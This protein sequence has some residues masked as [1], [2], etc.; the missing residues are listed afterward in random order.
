MRNPIN[1]ISPT[2]LFLLLIW[3]CERPHRDSAREY[4]CL[5]YEPELVTLSGTLQTEQRYGPPNYGEDP[6]TDMKM[7]ILV[8]HLSSPVE[9]CGEPGN[10]VNPDSFNNLQE[11]QLI[12]EPGQSYDSLVGRMVVA[13]GALEQATLGPH[14]TKVVMN[15]RE[16]HTSAH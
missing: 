10:R 3:A 4:T 11:I 6:K 1:R 16:V 9:T 5:P 14:F 13:Q 15:A 2:A 8:L 12:V 7:K